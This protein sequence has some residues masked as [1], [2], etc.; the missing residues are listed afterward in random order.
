MLLL[1]GGW[2]ESPAAFVVADRPSN[3][4]HASPPPDG[5]SASQDTLYGPLMSAANL[6]GYTLYPVD[7]PGF[8]PELRGDASVAL[9]VRDEPEAAFISDSDA[10]RPIGATQASGGAF[11]VERERLQHT[12][13]TRLARA[14]GGLPMIND[15]R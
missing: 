3:A 6:I 10:T 8:S 12:V 11:L 14:T 4:E 7:V 9:D 5:G 1:A 15:K 2:P 13:L